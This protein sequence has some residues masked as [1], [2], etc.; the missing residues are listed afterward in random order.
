ML[1]TDRLK[2]LACA[3]IDE[4]S[5]EIIGIAQDILA[6]PEPG[7]SEVRT[8]QVVAKKFTDLGIEH[9]QGLAITGVKGRFA[10]GAG[11]GPKVAIIGE[12]DSLLVSEHPHADSETGAAHAC[13]H[14]CQIGMIDRKSVV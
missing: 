7:F 12:L 6:H 10:G 13:G 4:K 3:A 11:P 5:S 2:E 14:H 1:S 9:E 8:A